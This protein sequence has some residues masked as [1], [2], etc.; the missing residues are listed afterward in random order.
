MHPNNM[1]MIFSTLEFD[2]KQIKMDKVKKKLEII[3]YI[4]NPILQL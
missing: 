4:K 3:V 2:N 1:F